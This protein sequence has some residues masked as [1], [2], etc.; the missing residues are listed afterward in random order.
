MQIMLF[1]DI[2]FINFLTPYKVF[3]IFQMFLWVN[4]KNITFIGYLSIGE[5]NATLS[6]NA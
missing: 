4:L 6:V 3:E 2:F 1:I 5:E